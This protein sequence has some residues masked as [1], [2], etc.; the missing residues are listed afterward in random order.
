MLP[1][2]KKAAKIVGGGKANYSELARLLGCQRPSLYVWKHVPICYMKKLVAATNGQI[3][4]EMVR[5]DI[6][7][8]A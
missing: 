6:F 8:G 1:V 3:T 5:P 4:L 2:I 7:K